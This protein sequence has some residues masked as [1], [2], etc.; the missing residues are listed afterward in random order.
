MSRTFRV[1]IDRCDWKLQHADIGLPTGNGKKLSCNQA[2][3][4]A[5]ASF[6]SIS[7]WPS[8]VCTLY[9]SWQWIFSVICLNW[10]IYT[11]VVFFVIL[12]SRFA[13][14]GRMAIIQSR[15][16]PFFSPRVIS[17]AFLPLFLYNAFI[18]WNG[19]NARVSPCSAGSSNRLTASTYS[20][21]LL[22]HAVFVGYGDT[23][24]A[25]VIFL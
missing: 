5:V 1:I 21:D 15:L 17:A 24:K 12:Y 2:T 14:D 18:P 20:G 19:E 13:R 9:W 11:E 7:C 4:L 22:W 10:I 6:L 23:F 3:G 8:Y 16:S 25:N